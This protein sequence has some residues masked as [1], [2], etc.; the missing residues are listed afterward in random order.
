MFDLHIYI[1][2]DD[3]IYRE[4]LAAVLRDQ[5][6]PKL[7]FT[8]F[9][10]TQVEKPLT[11]YNEL[12]QKKIAD[13]DVFLLDIDLKIF[14]DGIDFGTLIREQNRV[15]P[16]F[17]ITSSKSKSIEVINSGIQPTNYLVKSLDTALLIE[18]L[19]HFFT[20]FEQEHI[21]ETKLKDQNILFQAGTKKLLLNL[22][23]IMYISSIPSMRN[24]VI[25]KTATEEMIVDGTLN[26]IK[27]TLPS[28]PFYLGLK[29]Y[30]FNLHSIQTLQRS[31]SRIT[32]RDGEELFVG[33]AIIDKLVKIL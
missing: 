12:P 6:Q 23:E 14:H 21:E 31:E 18:R 15:S 2:E 7:R 5:I 10:I 17:F 27:Q 16:I 25:L 13:S 24:S 9:I 30:I 26:K 11:F 1:V 19:I 33:K 20:T 22:K 32:F 4:K 3:F 8:H 29:S 28:P